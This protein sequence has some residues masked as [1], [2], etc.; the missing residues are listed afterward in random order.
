MTRR[1]RLQ[2]AA[3]LFVVL[4]AM[5]SVALYSDYRLGPV[6][7]QVTRL[8]KV[9]AGTPGRG[10]LVGPVGPRG[11]Q[12]PRGSAGHN[13]LATT[14]TVVY[15]KRQPEAGIRGPVGP[16]GHAGARGL[17]GRP[18]VAGKAGPTGL[19]GVAG[20]TVDQVLQALCAKSL[21]LKP[22]CS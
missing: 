6:Q 9:V 2:A 15:V 5:V 7:K 3:Y 16:Q 11:R 14:K 8:T 17:Q 20:A 13:A 4:M 22:L 18:G 10:G 1:E 21:A 12:G 19:P